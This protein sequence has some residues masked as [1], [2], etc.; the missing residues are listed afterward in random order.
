MSP[1]TALVAVALAQHLELRV[2][3]P[4][5][6]T[7]KLS[8]FQLTWPGKSNQKQTNGTTTK[9]G[10]EQN[11]LALANQTHDKTI[12]RRPVRLEGRPRDRRLGQYRANCLC[13][14]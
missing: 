3:H 14:N 12:V 2:S 5:T 7:N 11:A 13:P 1:E 6:D 10:R 4:N 8:L 9:W